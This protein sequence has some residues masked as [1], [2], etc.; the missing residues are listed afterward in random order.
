MLAKNDLYIYNKLTYIL[1]KAWWR[2]G[3]TLRVNT[4]DREFDFGQNLRRLELLK[5]SDI[6][7]CAP[8]F[9]VIFPPYDVSI[10]RVGVTSFL[11]HLSHN[12]CRVIF[13]NNTEMVS[14]KVYKKREFCIYF[15]M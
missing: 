7:R 11:E 13:W 14:A 12:I 15:K 1:C 9:G 8:L 3:T 2:A 10:F 5:I 4:E 6:S